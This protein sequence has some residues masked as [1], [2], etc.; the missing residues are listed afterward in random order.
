[1]TTRH[2]GNAVHVSTVKITIEV[3]EYG[4]RDHVSRHVEAQLDGDQAA[5]L[6]RAF[7]GLDEA[8]ARL[9]NGRRITSNADV[10]RYLLERIGAGI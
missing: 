5:A 10:I 1:M 4:K 3:A 6:K 9:A 7:V 8:G 2:N